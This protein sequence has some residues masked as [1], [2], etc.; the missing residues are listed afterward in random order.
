MECIYSIC[1]RYLKK[2]QLFRFFTIELNVIVSDYWPFPD[3]IIIH[4]KLSTRFCSI[5]VAYDDFLN[6]H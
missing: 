3:Y 4:M 6:Q 2:T 5:Y 1:Y